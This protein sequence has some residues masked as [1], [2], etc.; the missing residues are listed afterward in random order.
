MRLLL[1]THVLIWWTT[2]FKLIPKRVRDELQSE[3]TEAFVSVV[4]A[5]EIATKVRIGKLKF[6]VAFLDDFDTSVRALAFEPLDITAKHAVTGASL[7]S[8]HK[9]PFDRLLAGQAVCENL[10]LVSAD[11]AM[12]LLG[13]D[14]LW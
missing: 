7:P 3:D 11:P 12:K 8:K 5:W 13:A 14:P 4:A 6:N 10:K 9:D 2:N 1:D